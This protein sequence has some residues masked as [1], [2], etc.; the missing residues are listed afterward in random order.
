MKLVDANVLL[1]AVNEGSARHAEA[2][3]WLD[4][5]LSGGE[6]VAFAWIAILAF[7][8]LATHQAVFARPLTPDDALDVV[9]YWLG[10]PTATVAEPTSRH[11][12]VLAQ[13]LVGV[14]TA[15]NLVNDAHLAA[16]ALEHGCEIV[17]YDADFAR[18]P[19][20][21]WETPAATTS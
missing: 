11:L 10:R 7:L 6:T 5:A 15:G 8:R 13:L 14:G 1:Y 16:L 12:E 4:T 9:R 2:R 20:V 17:S 3:R 19:G 21:R 18:F